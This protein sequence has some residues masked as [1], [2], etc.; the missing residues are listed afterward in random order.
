MV[1][2]KASKGKPKS[3]AIK[4]WVESCW[5][6]YYQREGQL[7]AG[8]PWDESYLDFTVIGPC[9]YKIKEAMVE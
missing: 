8:M 3:L 6:L 1:F 2:D 9:P 4:N 7:D 5:N